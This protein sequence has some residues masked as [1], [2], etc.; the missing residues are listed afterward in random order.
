MDSNKIIHFVWGGNTG[1]TKL[2]LDLVAT[3]NQN[4]NFNVLLVLRGNPANNQPLVDELKSRGIRFQF[5]P[6]KPKY[7]MIFK[8]I[9]IIKEFKPEIVVAHGYREHIYG[10][11]AAIIAKTPLI[12]Q[13]EHNTDKYTF[14]LYLMSRLL[15]RFT[16]KI[17]CVST[18][19]KEHLIKEGFDSN[20]LVVI[21]NGI[22]LKKYLPDND[23]NYSQRK[24][25][26]IMVARFA[27]QKDHYA[28]IQA[29]KI[30]KEQ[31]QPIAINFVGDGETK[32]RYQTLCK[33]LQLEDYVRFWG[34]RT[35][36]PNLLAQ[37]QIFALITH[38][39]GFGLV[40]A[41]AMAAGCLVIASNVP[42]IAELIKDR[43]TGF[44]VQPSDANGL[45]NIIAEIINNPDL[46]QE[47][48]LRGQKYALANFGLPTMVEKY[49][50]LFIEE[51]NNKIN[52]TK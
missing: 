2:V 21:H 35:D 41:E 3:Q 12:F 6:K 45:A 50:K 10:R 4:G 36:V 16:D 1:S 25:E 9:K 18:A 8:L 37:H 22:D 17:I 24:R 19:V 40:V 14:K 43:E 26:I 48:A 39:E 13:V 27:P 29:A 33:E 49:E 5:V 46:A 15:T 23:N 52:T 30:L 47:I 34:Q 11:I 7:S 51:Y 32:E 42:A 28:L 44:L 31:N 20:K 38:Y